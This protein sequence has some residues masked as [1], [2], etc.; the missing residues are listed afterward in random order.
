ML[1][2]RPAP[3][4]YYDLQLCYVI[5][6]LLNF[7]KN[8]VTPRMQYGPKLETVSGRKMQC[9]LKR[10]MVETLLTFKDMKNG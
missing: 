5:K 1:N 6:Q 10:L 9:G 3:L 7:Q 2:S 4:T 8:Q